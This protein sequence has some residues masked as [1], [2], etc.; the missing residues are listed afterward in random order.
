MD[1]EM[2]MAVQEILKCLQIKDLKTEQAKILKALLQR[3]DYVAVLLTGY[4]KSLPHH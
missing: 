4:G 2:K 3:K 1:E